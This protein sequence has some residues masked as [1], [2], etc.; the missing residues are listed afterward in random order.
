MTG[1]ADGVQARGIILLMIRNSTENQ[2]SH[3]G[4]MAVDPT[5]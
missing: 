2:I 1:G 3:Y 4:Y 5:P